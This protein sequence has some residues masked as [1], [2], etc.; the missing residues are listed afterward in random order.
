MA[1]VKAGF[2]SLPVTQKIVKARYYVSQMTGNANFPTPDPTLN[3]V[4]SKAD[5][6]EQA[7]NDAQDGSKPKIALAKAAEAELDAI[8]VLLIAYVQYVSKGDETIIKSS[9]FEIKE[10]KTTPLPI[11]MVTGLKAD[12]GVNEGEV[13]LYW[14]RIANSKVYK[15]EKS[16]DGNTNWN[17]AGESV[18]ASITLT[19]L[20]TAT[21]IWFRIA[22][23]GAKGQGPWS[24]PAKGLVS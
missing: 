14:D 3:N 18:K 17:Y 16:A 2:S 4:G 8:I 20:P 10:N 15:I 9:G 23:V 7:F 21:K 22:G 11:P 12:P 19:S 5:A 24:D 1:T 13:N 6:L